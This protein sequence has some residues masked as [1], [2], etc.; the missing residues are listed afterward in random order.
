MRWER[1]ANMEQHELS[2]Q[3]MDIRTKFEQQAAVQVDMNAISILL[4]LCHLSGLDDWRSFHA[5]AD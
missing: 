4:L 5:R 2:K 3:A 1:L